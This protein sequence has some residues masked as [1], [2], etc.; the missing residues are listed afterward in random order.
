MFTRSNAPGASRASQRTYWEISDKASAYECRRCESEDR[1]E[2]CSSVIRAT[3]SIACRRHLGR[4]IRR[5][6]HLEELKLANRRRTSACQDIQPHLT[7]C[8]F[9]KQIYLFDADR[10]RSGHALPGTPCPYLDR[11]LHSRYSQSGLSATSKNVV[12]LGHKHNVLCPGVDDR[13]H[14]LVRIELSRIECRGT[15]CSVALRIEPDRRALELTSVRHPLSP[16]DLWLRR[17][18][19]PTAAKAEAALRISKTVSRYCPEGSGQR[20]LRFRSVLK[21]DRDCTEMLS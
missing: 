10:L 8:D 2:I 17:N 7:G 3:Q 1:A 13:L 4:V 11:V 21:A 20:G 18:S 15:R 9:R 19:I 6:L 16:I 12:M 14:P 5:W